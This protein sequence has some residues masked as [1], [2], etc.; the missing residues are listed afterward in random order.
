M[1]KEELGFRLNR[2]RR[3]AGLTQKEFAHSIGMT[4][5]QYKRYEQ[6]QNEPPMRALQSIARGLKMT[7]SELLCEAP[8]EGP[9]FLSYYNALPENIRGDVDEIIKS[10]CIKH[11]RQ[12]AAR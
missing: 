1:D 9:P 7:V 8:R 5:S 11:S 12:Q 2:L 10:L 4:E 3:A 6:G